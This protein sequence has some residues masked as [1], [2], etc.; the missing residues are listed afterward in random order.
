MAARRAVQGTSKPGESVNILAWPMW[1]GSP[2]GC[3][4]VFS[5]G[6]QGF[7]TPSGMRLPA[8]SIS[9]DF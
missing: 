2:G 5:R 7:G 9:G 1:V 3:E 6:G 8:R 4:L